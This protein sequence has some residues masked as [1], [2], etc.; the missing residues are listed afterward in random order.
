ME[1]LQKGITATP[2]D[3]VEFNSSSL[4]PDVS[5]ELSGS[6]TYLVA[7]NVTS[8]TVPA[9]DNDEEAFAPLA[10]KNKNYFKLP[11]DAAVN[12]ILSTVGNKLGLSEPDAELTFRMA[13]EALVAGE[14]AVDAAEADPD[15][16]ETD[17]LSRLNGEL[18]NAVDASIEDYRKDVAAQIA[19]Q[20]Y[21]GDVRALSVD[22]EIA[23]SRED[24]ESES[25][26]VVPDDCSA[27]LCVLKPDS[28]GAEASEEI[29]EAVFAAID[30]Y[31]DTA[32]TAE[33]IASG[34]ISESIVRRVPGAIDE[35]DRPGYAREMES[36]EWRA[37]VQ[38]A[39]KHVVRDAAAEQAVTLSDT[40]TV[41]KLDT[42]IRQSLEAVSKE[43]RRERF[44]AA[45]SNGSFN[46]EDYDNWVNGTQTPVRAPA[47]LPVF[48]VPSHWF[49]TV[50]AWN[51]EVKGA[52]ARF[53]VVANVGTPE[54]AATMTYVREDRTVHREIAGRERR[55]GSVEQI[56]FSGQSVLIVA[57]PP[58]KLGVGDR[59]DENP[60][61]SP[62][63]PVVGDIS[64]EKI[65]CGGLSAVNS[66]GLLG[67]QTVGG[68]G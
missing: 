56:E 2:P 51:V 7:E 8:E 29:T 40:D 53:E 63:W 37:V 45:V 64:A 27:T 61:C 20:L 11:Y 22:G 9:V 67:Q 42:E 1:F 4:T 38:S 54:T 49:A 41:E 52:Y 35:D 65:N 17:K 34:E 30:G 12:G 15:Y 21:P 19:F 24:C 28:D 36:A 66:L 25:C 26:V 60:E 6:P 3:P 5:Y 55:L 10:T 32:E 16:G 43:I 50:N 23:R 62:T 59:D 39:I 58:G 48:P 18:E 47:G 44:D 57:V 33:A 14:E 68:P 46:I 31:G 13:S